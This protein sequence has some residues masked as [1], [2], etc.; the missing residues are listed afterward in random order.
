[1]R[2]GKPIHR[3]E[4]INESDYAIMM[5]YQTEYRGMVQYYILAHN[6]ARLSQ[7]RYVME[8]SLLKT[9]AAKHKAK[10]TDIVQR[11]KATVDTENGPLKCLQTV[12]Q[13][14]S[15]K[16]PL[17]ARFGGIPLRR[18]QTATLQDKIYTVYTKRTDLVD[19]MLADRC[20]ICG[21]EEGCEVHHIRKLANLHRIDRKDR[22]EWMHRMIALRRKTLVVCRK[23]HEAIHKGWP[24]QK[25]S[26]EVTGE[27]DAVKAARP[28]RGRDG[29]KG[30]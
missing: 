15:D 21:S 17:V 24:Y 16:P 14:G 4:L 8:T 13:R 12:V 19:R 5:R 29:G 2:N 3:T 23:C 1:M 6:I 28:V 27:P 9:L 20:E 25:R 11:C 22:P 10:V 30:P 18:K 26:E 7:V